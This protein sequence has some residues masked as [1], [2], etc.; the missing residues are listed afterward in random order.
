M[1]FEE[2]ANAT[3]EKIKEKLA[4]NPEIN[5]T[6]HLE[7]VTKNNGVE[8]TA[9]VF[10]DSH[11]KLFTSPAFYLNAAYQ[12][13]ISVEDAANDA[14]YVL[15]N[16]A[17]KDNPALQGFDADNFVNDLMDFDS[18]KNHIFP[19]VIN[20]EANERFLQTVPHKV[21]EDLA[22][23]YAYRIN[24]NASVKID[25]R[26]L[27]IYNIS[28]EELHNLAVKNMHSQ[29]QPQMIRLSHILVRN[30]VP[31]FEQM[32]E[33][34]QNNYLSRFGFPLTEVEEQM[35]VISNESKLNGAACILDEDFMKEVTE[36][37]PNA[38]FL[39]SSIHELIVIK[40]NEEMTLDVL[41]AL[42]QQVNDTEVLAQEVLSDHPYVYDAKTKEL[43]S[44]SEENLNLSS[45]DIEL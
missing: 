17:A 9:V 31:G 12:N 6:P 32:D 40:P 16:C 33:E 27:Q 36:K 26:L 7:T 13:N 41:S 43:V 1:T 38:I 25:N 8:L 14:I 2:F 35:F 42:I 45:D 5:V 34:T 24:E 23:T 29:D 3:I 18:A 39:P 19:K 10:H 20:K 30:M 21:I 4:E 44:M 22:V 11:Q 37:I 15:N 28:A